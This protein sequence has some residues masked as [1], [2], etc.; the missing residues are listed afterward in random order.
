LRLETYIH[1]AER[2]G[3]SVTVELFQRAQKHSKEGGEQAKKRSLT[4]RVRIPA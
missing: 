1:D 2:D 4:T 3:D